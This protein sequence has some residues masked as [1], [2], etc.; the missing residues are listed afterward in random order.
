MNHYNNPSLRK[1]TF[2]FE[3]KKRYFEQVKKNWNML[4]RNYLAK[5]M[6]VSLS[7]GDERFQI[8]VTI[9]ASYDESFMEII[10]RN[11]PDLD[12]EEFYVLS[13]FIE[14]TKKASIYFE[15][16]KAKHN[17]DM[18]CE[19]AKY[20]LKDFDLLKISNSIFDFLQPDNPDVFG[21]YKIRTSEVELYIFP[22]TLFCQLHGLDLES[23][24]VMVLTHEL[25]HA[26]N[27]IGR[28][29]DGQYWESFSETDNNLAEGLAQFYTSKFLHNYQFRNYNLLSTFEQTIKYQ[30]EPYSVF[31][32][33]NATME[34]VY[35]AFIEVRRN[36]FNNYD[37]YMSALENAKGRIG[38]K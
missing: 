24:I 36:D 14:N 2:E 28:D 35:R 17:M 18:A 27:H 38:R 23:F 8:S 33:W 21:C 37:Q 11:F 6:G 10:E 16:K 9:K 31:K 30:P 32:N 13:Q 34:Q 12:F 26:Y 1:L 5:N 19:Y 20:R 29:K 4:I 25:S 15:D 3:D 7:E 22:I